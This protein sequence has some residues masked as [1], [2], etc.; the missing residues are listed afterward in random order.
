[1][2]VIIQKGKQNWE[3]KGFSE[4][5]PAKIYTSVTEAATTLHSYYLIGK[6][7]LSPEEWDEWGEQK[8]KHDEFY[9]ENKIYTIKIKIIP[10][11]K[12]EKLIKQG[13]IR[14]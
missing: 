8:M 12:A 3:G 4:K 7:E 10:E 5:L 13:K 1:M 9:N 2:Y 11:Q 14:Y 6:S